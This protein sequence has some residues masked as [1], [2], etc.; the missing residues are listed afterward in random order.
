[1]EAGVEHGKAG[2][3]L[4]ELEANDY[5]VAAEYVITVNE[6]ENVSFPLLDQLEALKDSPLKLLMSSLTLEGDHGEEDPTPEFR[7]L[8]P[9]FDQVTVSV[10]YERGGSRDPRSI[11]NEILL[12]D[13]LAA[14]QVCAEKRRKGASLSLET[15][16]PSVVMPFASS[17]ETSL[18]VADY[19]I[20]SVTIVDGTVLATE[21]HDDLFDTTLLDKPVDHQFTEPRSS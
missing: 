13:A 18:V 4:A 5:G 15:G 1:M 6:L 7:K 8:Q 17:Q 19:Q 14:S 21:A 2:R 9:V 10:Y 16:G 3:S 11:S 20:L 12:F